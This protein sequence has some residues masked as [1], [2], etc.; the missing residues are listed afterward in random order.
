MAN[1]VTLGNLHFDTQAQA[2]AYFKAML[3]RYRP[4]DSIHA[5]D[6]V[7]LHHLIERHAEAP[8]K[9]GCGI[10]RFYVERTDK[11]TCC[12]WL[13]RTDG[14]Y[15]DFSYISCIKARAKTLDQAFKEACREAVVDDLVAAKKAHFD[16]HGD[17]SGRV[18]CDITG[19]L[20]LPHECHLDHAHPMTFEVIVQ[21]FWAASGIEPSRDIL[22]ASQD[23]Q[24]AT[25]FTDPGIA[26]RFRDFHHR[27]AQLRI[28]QSNLNLSLG[29]S[30]RMRTPKRPVAIKTLLVAGVAGN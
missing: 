21:T 5:T 30:M 25:T 3:A 11:G 18:P 20:L 10:A 4:G 29:G 1:P 27:V 12:F 17:E 23:Q 26:Q 2:L 9:I 6:A 8:Q 13:E 19:E 16:A 14:S 28:V 15:T 24:F 7:H 22:S